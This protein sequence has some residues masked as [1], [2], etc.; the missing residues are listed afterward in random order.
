MQLSVGQ[1]IRG[2]RA[3]LG[4]T[5]QELADHLGLTRSSV[6]NIESGNQS[7]TLLSFLKIAAE[8]EIAPGEL[9]DALSR[10]TEWTSW[11]RN[12]GLP[13]KYMHMVEAV[14]VGEPEG[15]DVDATSAALR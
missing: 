3:K 10:E 8:L 7:L 11:T 4:L 13:D 5:Q 14:S 9:L 6:S 2:R 1:A 15:S 12:F